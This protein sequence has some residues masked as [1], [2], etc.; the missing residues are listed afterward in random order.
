MLGEKT[1]CGLH[2]VINNFGKGKAMNNPTKSLDFIVTTLH[3]GFV[4]VVLKDL[5]SLQN[6]QTDRIQVPM[7]Y[8]RVQTLITFCEGYKCLQPIANS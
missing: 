1:S 6:S 2:M 8:V 3:T 7:V 4:M 5:T